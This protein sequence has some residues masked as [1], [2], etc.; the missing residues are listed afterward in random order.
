MSLSPDLNK[1]VRIYCIKTFLRVKE[2]STDILVVVKCMSDFLSYGYYCTVSFPEFKES[3][4]G[5]IAGVKKYIQ[6]DMDEF[7][8]FSF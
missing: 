8:L 6:F 5:E 3:F 2:N 7:Y 4:S 1:F